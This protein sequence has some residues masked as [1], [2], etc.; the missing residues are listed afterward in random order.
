MFLCPGSDDPDVGPNGEEF[1]RIPRGLRWRLKFSK[2]EQDPRYGTD[3]LKLKNNR[4]IKRNCL[5]TEYE[6]LRIVDRHTSIPIPKVVGVWQTRDAKLVE[7]EIMAGKPLDT[8][9][10][11]LNLAQKR[12][13]TKDL[14][15][16]VDQLRS[17]QPPK[18]TLIGSA[19][20]GAA[21][22]ERFGSGRIGP[23]YTLDQFH[24]FLRRGH[25]TADFDEVELKHCHDAAKS[26]TMKFTHANL[27]PRNVLIDDSCRVASILGWEHAGWYPEYWEYT[28]MHHIAPKAMLD[29]LEEM[30]KVV[31]KYEEELAADDALRSRYLG[32]VYD[33]PRSVRMPS[34]TPSELDQERQAIDD[35]NTEN[36]S[37]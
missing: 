34:P 9:W 12:K 37:G 25:P 24:D 19:S 35:K 4:Y 1:D 11:S 30:R 22:D 16:F 8:M 20:M 28:Q 21:Y 33:S 26:Y 2:K 3:V 29:W 10:G 6:A 17:M 23:F 36:T 5:S 13:V 7:Y 18:H 32:S 14:G 31:P 27:C 15:R